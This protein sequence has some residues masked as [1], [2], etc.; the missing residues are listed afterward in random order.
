MLKML[1]GTKLAFSQLTTTLLGDQSCASQIGTLAIVVVVWPDVT[2]A[3]SGTGQPHRVTGHVARPNQL[4]AK[5]MAAHLG[6]FERL[7]Q[8]AQEREVAYYVHH[9]QQVP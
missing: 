5:A 6:V 3:L 9:Q 8:Q 7:G 2:G 1:K 4:P